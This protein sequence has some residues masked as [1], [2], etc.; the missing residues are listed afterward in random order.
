[1]GVGA[2]ESQAK[3]SEAPTVLFVWLEIHSCIGLRVASLEAVEL[4]IVA[5]MD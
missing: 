4:A 5:D 3:N 2:A 1:M